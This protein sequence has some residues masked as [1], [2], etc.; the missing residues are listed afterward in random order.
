MQE[1]QDESLVQKDST[2]HEAAE[3]MYRNYWTSALEPVSPSHWAHAP[4]LL[5]P[6]QLRALAGAPQQEEPPQRE[7]STPHLESFPRFTTRE[8]S[9]EQQ[10]PSTDK[11]KQT[12]RI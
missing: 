2:C 7:A 12:D 8:K 5:K 10:K 3:P 11:N 4:Q 6:T 9:A 1:I